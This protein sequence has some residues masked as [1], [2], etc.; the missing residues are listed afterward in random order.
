MRIEG[1]RTERGYE[2]A[3]GDYVIQS[4]TLEQARADAKLAAAIKRN[5]WPPIET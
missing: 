5:G 4:W 1:R 2:L 3:Q